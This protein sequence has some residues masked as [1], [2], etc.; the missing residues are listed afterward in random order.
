MHVHVHLE[1]LP[2]VPLWLMI[3]PFSWRLL[4]NINNTLKI[5]GRFIIQNYIVNSLTK[6]CRLTIYNVFLFQIF[7][8][9]LPFLDLIKNHFK[10]NCQGKTKSKD[11]KP[12]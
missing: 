6:H 9:I 12:K 1:L 5:H 3:L 4:L 7:F 2:T 8:L 10:L 11:K